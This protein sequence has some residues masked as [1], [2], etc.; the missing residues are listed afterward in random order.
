MIIIFTTITFE[1]DTI[2]G[3][4]MIAYFTCTYNI[5]W[6]LFS[7]IFTHDYKTLVKKFEKN[8]MHIINNTYHVKI[9]E[10]KIRLSGVIIN[11]RIQGIHIII[12]EIDKLVFNS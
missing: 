4:T 6:H 1:F 5:P 9:F 11:T 2:S 3:N 10:V 12:T 8:I 7:S